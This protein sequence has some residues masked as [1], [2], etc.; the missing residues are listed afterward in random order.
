M[1][2]RRLCGAMAALVIGC[3][4]GGAAPAAPL[5]LNALSGGAPVPL[6]SLRGAPAILV[7][8]RADC[9]PCR[10]ELDNIKQLRAAAGATRL[11]L[12]GLGPA[13]PLRAAM[14]HMSASPGLAWR[15]DA[16]PASVLLAFNGPPPR[17]PLSI[18]L[19]ARGRICARRVGLLGTDQIARWAKSCAS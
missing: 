6:S 19:D 7:F 2:V 17:L 11:I 9:A 1:T 16:D 13:D 4:A 3:C 5:Q 8:W 14:A 15:A 12:V 18:A 10:L